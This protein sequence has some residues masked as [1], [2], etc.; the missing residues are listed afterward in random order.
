VLGSRAYPDRGS[1]LRAECALKRQPMARKL[2]GRL[3][4]ATAAS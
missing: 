3:D 2:A 4:G 1:A